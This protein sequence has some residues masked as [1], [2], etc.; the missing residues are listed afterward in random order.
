MESTQ[1]GADREVLNGQGMI[2][3]LGEDAL[4]AVLLGDHWRRI[5]LFEC[6]VKRLIAAAGI[7]RRMEARQIEV[8]Q[9][10]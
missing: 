9:Q 4:P 8:L 7:P 1:S 2:E 10:F 5:P 3:A 6:D